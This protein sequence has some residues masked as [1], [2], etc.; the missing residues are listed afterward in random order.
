MTTTDK[1]GHDAM[2]AEFDT[3]AE[4]TAEVAVDLGPSDFVPA[5]CRGS[6]SPAGLTWLL[7]ALEVHAGDRMLDCGAGVGGPSGYARNERG[8]RPILIEPERGACRAARWLFDLPTMQASADALPLAS[9]VFD[10]AWSLGVLCTMPDQLALLRELRR[11]VRAPTRIGLLVYVAQTDRLS[12]QPA[13]NHFPRPDRLLG[14]IAAAGLQVE[15]RTTLGM[16]APEPASWRDEQAA[17][18]AE[19]ERRHR[20]TAAW[21]I[22]QHQSAVL[23]RLIRSGELRGELLSLRSAR[24]AG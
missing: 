9:G 24:R 1:A 11:V 7:D 8:V 10:V 18:E 3:V 21:Q 13:G 16:L 19:L 15:A 6:A 5:G 17:V 4:W 23:G 20:G 12:E 2:D 14:L 22:A